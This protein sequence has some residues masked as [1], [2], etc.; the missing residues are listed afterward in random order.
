M[1]RDGKGFKTW[2]KDTRLWCKITKVPEKNKALMIYLHGIPDQTKA[3]SVVQQI[4][5]DK[6]QSSEGVETLM[7]VLDKALLPDKPMRLFNTNKMFKDTKRGNTTKVH[8]F[9]IEFEHARYLAELEGITFDNTLLGLNLLDQCQ[10]AEDK[11]QLVMSGLTQINYETVKSKLQSIFFNEQDTN[12]QEQI[13]NNARDFEN[14]T[15]LASEPEVFYSNSYNRSRGGRGYRSRGRGRG[16]DTRS[17]QR[18]SR[19]ENQQPYRKMNPEDRNGRT[20]RCN[21]CDSRFHWAR[22]CPHAH[23]NQGKYKEQKSKTRSNSDDELFTLFVARAE[24]I[25]NVTMFA[26][27]NRN[28]NNKMKA[29]REETRGC[30]IIDSGCATNVCGAQWMEDFKEALTAEQKEKIRE[31]PSDQY[32]SFGIGGTVKARCKTKVPCWLNGKRGSLTTHIVDEDM[33]LLLS[34]ESLV[35][36]NLI[37]DFGKALLSSSTG[38]TVVK[39]W[40]TR[41]GHFALPINL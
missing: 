28:N 5:E 4:P 15:L 2:K 19:S 39:L 3:K 27:N 18:Y 7:E 1:A 24:K 38:N 8:D 31:E 22:S 13:S 37:V 21:I 29:L 41:S 6:L 11:Q 26:G 23:E 20:T 25:E 17:T 40:N 9:I 30:A 14:Q 36:M 32:F 33:P 16:G 10:L 12:R 34:K 35:R